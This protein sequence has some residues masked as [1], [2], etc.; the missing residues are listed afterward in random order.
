MIRLLSRALAREEQAYAELPTESLEELQQD[1]LIP[2]IG[3]LVLGGFTLFSAIH[4]AE[5]ILHGDNAELFVD[6]LGILLGVVGAY[7]VNQPAQMVDRELARRQ[8]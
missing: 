8:E 4:G 6:G 5:A 7:V 1:K 2:R 3:K